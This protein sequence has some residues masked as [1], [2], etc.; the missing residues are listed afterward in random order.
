M[1]WVSSIR[2]RDYIAGLQ[3]GTIDADDSTPALSGGQLVRISGIDTDQ[4]SP[5]S[6]EQLTGPWVGYDWR[7]WNGGDSDL[8]NLGAYNLGTDFSLNLNESTSGGGVSYVDA[9]VTASA[10]GLNWDAFGGAP[11]LSAFTFV[12]AFAGLSGGSD[13]PADHEAYFALTGSEADLVFEASTTDLNAVVRGAW[14]LDSDGSKVEVNDGDINPVLG[15]VNKVVVITLDIPTGNENGIW[16][17]TAG[18]PSSVT[19]RTGEYASAP[20]PDYSTASD[21]VMTTF[22]VRMRRGVPI[23]SLGAPDT[24]CYAI[25]LYRGAPTVGDLSTIQAAFGV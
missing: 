5:L 15:F 2:L 19:E 23:P 6:Y 7:E 24:G 12:A 21:P 22:T 10:A 9:S 11:D 8:Q 4:G 25:A 16:T 20:Y 14:T 3:V 13:V 18:M 1:T 17:N